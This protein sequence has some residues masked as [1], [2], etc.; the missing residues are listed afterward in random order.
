L[1]RRTLSGFNGAILIVRETFV[2]RDEYS[3]QFGD[4]TGPLIL[5]RTD[6]LRTDGFE[7]AIERCLAFRDV[8]CDMTVSI[9]KPSLRPDQLFCLQIIY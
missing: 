9:T 5:A 8:G 6:A 2:I 7:A 4:G 3:A 1:G